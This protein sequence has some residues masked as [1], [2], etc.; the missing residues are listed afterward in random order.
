MSVLVSHSTLRLES[1]DL[2]AGLI[3]GAFG[4]AMEVVWMAGWHAQQ[5]LDAAP[6]ARGVAATFAPRLGEGASG[7]A[8][9]V[10]IHMALSLALGLAIAVA[11]R[12]LL[13]AA[14]RPAR[15]A[16]VFATLVAI[17]AIN[18]F[19][20]LPI[21]N[22]AF[23]TVVPYGVSLISKALFGVAAA[24]ALSGAGARRAP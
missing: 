1:A 19:V 24:L 10:A 23:V 7:V 11:V 5:A 18:F 2:R 21:V 20:V 3:A 14:S 6:V 13:G 9:G 16:A 15:A 17:W 4:G 12:T 8:L 22:P